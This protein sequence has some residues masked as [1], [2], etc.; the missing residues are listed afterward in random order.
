MTDRDWRIFREDY[1]IQTKG[2]VRHPGTGK[3]IRPFRFWP[4]SGLPDNILKAIEKVGYKSPT[5]VQMQCIPLGLACKDVIGVA[6]TG[7]TPRPPC[8]HFLLP[9]PPAHAL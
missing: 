2:N 6:K 1:E 8:P 9:S 5:G 3:Q 4:E 7:A